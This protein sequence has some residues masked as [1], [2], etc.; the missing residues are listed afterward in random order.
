MAPQKVTN[1]MPRVTGFQWGPV[2][3]QR[4]QLAA[5]VMQVIGL[6][7]AIDGMFNGMLAD[8]LKLDIYV[9]MKM[10]QS[11]DNISLRRQLVRIAAEQTFSP[12]DFQ[13]FTATVKTT[14]ASETRRHAFA[15]HIWAVPNG[16]EHPNTL[17]L[18]DPKDFRM[19][20]RSSNEE[21]CQS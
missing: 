13:L 18:I 7:S 15:H 21:T 11:I 1:V 12:E 3:Q 20:R 14:K 4:P 19:E 2:I 17:L 8:F 10:L 5:L 6:W 9:A 16:D